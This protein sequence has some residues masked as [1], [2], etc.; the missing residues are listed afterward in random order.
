MSLFSDQERSIAKALAGL[1]YCN[2]FLPERIEFEKEA[3]GNQ[4]VPSDLVWS[5]R[6]KEDGERP[7]L[8]AL[9]ALAQRLAD[10]AREK[11]L[12]GQSAS[13]EDLALYQDIILYLLY[14]R[15]RT[16]L[17]EL[18]FAPNPRKAPGYSAFLSLHNRYVSFLLGTPDENPVPPAPV[19]PDVPGAPDVHPVLRYPPRLYASY[20]QIR[21]AFHHIYHSIV[22]SSMPAARLRA[23]AWQSVF[24]TDMRRYQRVLYD[25]LGDFTTLICGPSGTGKEVVARAIGLARYI[26]FD[27]KTQSFALDF[28]GSF[29]PLNLCALSPTLIESEL[30]GHRRGAFTGALE[31]R[32]GW[33]EVCQPLGCVFLDEVG[34]IDAAIQVKLLRV[35]QTRAFQ[36][37]GD[38]Q[39]RTFAGKIIAATNRDLCAQ[40]QAGRI[41]EDFYYR[42]CSD[43][44]TTPTL[45][46][47]L[48]ESP[49]EL[50]NLVLFIAL[51]VTQTHA[52]N[53]RDSATIPLEDAQELADQVIAWVLQH[54]GPDY[55]W[56]G[57][58]RE[59]EQCVR[60]V[61]IRGQY[62]PPRLSG[63][64]PHKA[65][66]Q[67][68]ES[69][70]LT[71][72]QLLRRYCTLMYAQTG[73]YEETARRLAIDRRTVKTK[74]DLDL[75]DQ[76]KRGE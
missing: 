41:R 3:L 75:L 43:M 40:M 59:L 49:Q 26:P 55:P 58:F 29:H 47:I 31:D 24:T 34:D 51:R 13:K 69:G 17:T 23:S 66:A 73:N 20:F 37:I 57:N 15:S 53:G 45:R 38:T 12:D 14:Q 71:A 52:H 64:Q 60:N 46:E 32:A 70:E 16:R 11:L 10:Q 56:P 74:V 44:V 50:R 1:N 4:F 9:E 67:A 54:L 7:N 62:L 61:L 28:R 35:L 5:I 68:L 8:A 65:L 30:F 36:R 18:I 48:R 42:L 33:L 72:D 63:G 25:R 19:T 39:T 21:R 2:P 6:A 27:E 22:G 76:L